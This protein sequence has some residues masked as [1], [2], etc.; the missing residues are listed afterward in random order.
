V[1]AAT[2]FRLWEAGVRDWESFLDLHR[3]GDLPHRRLA[4]IAPLV[5]ES[6]RA[7]GRR[8]IEFFADRL[9][10][11]EQWRLYADFREW[12]A[13]VDIETTGLIA[14]YDEITIIGLYDGDNFRAF[15]R[16]QNLEEFPAAAA[17]YDLL[18][19][20][21][22]STFDVPFLKATFPRFRPRAHLDL[23]Y[24]LR[25]LGYTGGLKEVER[26]L[27]IRRPSHLRDIDG[28]EAI[29]LWAEYK[30][31]RRQALDLLVEYCR[32]DVVNLLPLVQTVTMEMPHKVGFSGRPVSA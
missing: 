25:R 7:L 14:G 5:E 27:D 1:G 24:P 4:R 12:T 10:P 28:F 9:P 6:Q 19:S 11:H 32:Q 29:R 16:G 13:F 22:G 8:S 31:G 15:V 20:Y 21:N 18:V 17:H 2:E 23:R 26:R 3:S 30:R